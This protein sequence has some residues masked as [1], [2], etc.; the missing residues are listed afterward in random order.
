M[1]HS[2][3]PGIFLDNNEDKI[4]SLAFAEASIAYYEG[5]DGIYN[6]HKSKNPKDKEHMDRLA[7]LI[8]DRKKKS[9]LKKLH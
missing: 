7:K 5:G 1:V 8:I 2:I 3:L 4:C 9:F 6:F